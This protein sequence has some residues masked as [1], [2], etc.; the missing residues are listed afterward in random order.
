MISNVKGHKNAFGAL[1]GSPTSVCGAFRLVGDLTGDT[2]T[3]ESGLGVGGF[4]KK[5]VFGALG[6][7]GGECDGVKEDWPVVDIP[8]A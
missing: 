1:C 8:P 3:P 4:E 7:V 2:G 6:D 5:E